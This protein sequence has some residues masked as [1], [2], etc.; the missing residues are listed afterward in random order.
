MHN[1]WWMEMRPIKKTTERG[2]WLSHLATKASQHVHQNRTTSAHATT[3]YEVMLGY[4]NSLRGSF[5]QGFGSIWGPRTIPKFTNK[6][7]IL[8]QEQLPTVEAIESILFKSSSFL[9]NWVHFHSSEVVQIKT[10]TYSMLCVNIYL[11]FVKVWKHIWE[12]WMTYA[13][14]L[15]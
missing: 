14:K 12:N 3:K 4:S 6:K 1:V 2:I 9:L 11:P 13:T 5:Y 7:L 8:H 15:M 10:L